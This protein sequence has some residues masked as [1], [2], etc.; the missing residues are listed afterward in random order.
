MEHSADNLLEPLKLLEG[1]TETLKKGSEH[2]ETQLGIQLI[3]GVPEA[4]NIMAINYKT[5]PAILRCGVQMG[6]YL[7]MRLIENQKLEK[8]M[9][10]K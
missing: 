3:P 2:Y 8:L 4:I 10:D 9:G 6:V 1:V 7:H 5:D